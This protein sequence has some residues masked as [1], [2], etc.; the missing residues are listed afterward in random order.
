MC[1][2]VA[3]RMTEMRTVALQTAEE[4]ALRS[5]EEQAARVGAREIEQ[6]TIRDALQQAGKD[7]THRKTA[8]SGSAHSAGRYASMTR[9]PSRG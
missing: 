3:A 2:G 5:A 8:S 6:L 4:Q 9:S 1:N 7:A